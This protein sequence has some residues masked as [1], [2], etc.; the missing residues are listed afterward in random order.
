MATTTNDVPTRQTL[1]DAALRFWRRACLALGIALAG[2]PATGQTL[3][4]RL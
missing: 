3:A 1:V 2:L 4:A